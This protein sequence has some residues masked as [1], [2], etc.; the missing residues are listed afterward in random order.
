MGGT[1]VLVGTRKGAFVLTS[2]EARTDWK[3]ERAALPGLGDLPPQGLAGEPRPDLRLADQRLVRPGD[4]AVRRRRRVLGPGGQRLQLRRR[5]RRAPVVRR[6]AAAVGVHPGLAPRALAARRRDGVRR[7]RGRRAVQVHRRRRQL[8]RAVRPAQAR[9]RARSGSRAPAACAC[10]RSCSTRP[11]PTAST[12][13]SPRPARSAPT[14][15]AQTWQ[16]INKG[17]R[18]GEI[19]DQDSEV[20]HCVHNLAMHPADPDVLYMQK[21]W[22]VMRTKDGGD[23]WQEVSGNLPTDFGFPIAGARARAGDHLRR[24]D[25]QRLP[26]LPAR[27]QA[28]RLPQ[29]HRRRR[30]GGR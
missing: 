12:S 26:P 15:A 22:D 11:T 24:A 10:T 7:H 13:R 5:P 23:S 19:P 8:D 4:P 16:P 6:V 1:R 20:G 30:V 9:H 25:H 17:L 18:S 2:D 14:T 21:H 29:P 3:V 27:G 28:A